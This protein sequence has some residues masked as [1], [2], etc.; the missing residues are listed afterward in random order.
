M[1]LDARTEALET[2]RKGYDT[3]YADSERDSPAELAMLL[4]R[5]L[6]EVGKALLSASTSSEQTKKEGEG[7][8]WVLTGTADGVLL[9]FGTGTA[10]VGVD[11]AFGAML[12]DILGNKLRV[13]LVVRV[14][15]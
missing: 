2:L 12:N 6:C 3:A 7:V 5:E 14:K 1:T 13:E 9:D 10:A 11:F 15:E 8:T 4:M